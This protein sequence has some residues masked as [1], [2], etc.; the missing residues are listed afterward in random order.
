MKVSIRSNR[1]LHSHDRHMGGVQEADEFQSALIA[2]FILTSF[3][4]KDTHMSDGFN[5]L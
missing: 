2:V 3:T 5:P 4:S 1:G